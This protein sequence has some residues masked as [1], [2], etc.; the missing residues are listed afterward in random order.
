[1]EVVKLD[2][3]PYVDKGVTYVPLRF[4]SQAY[5]YVVKFSNNTITINTGNSSGSSQTTTNT[6]ANSNSSQSNSNSAADLSSLAEVLSQQVVHITTYDSGGEVL[7]LGS[8]V[9]YTSSGE[10]ITNYHVIEDADYVV[11]A[12]SDGKEY[13]SDLVL[14]YDENRD[15]AL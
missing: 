5:G 6:A 12:T 11:V 8:G 2:R 15:L 1:G 7:A 14:Q 10:I 3:A 9:I 4:V 13:K